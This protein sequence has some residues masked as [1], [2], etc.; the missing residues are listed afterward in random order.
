MG[1]ASFCPKLRVVD[2][3][4]A[5]HGGM[6]CGCLLGMAVASPFLPRSPA[7]IILLLP[8][9]HQLVDHNVA[10]TKE[11]DSTES[12][13]LATSSEKA[14]AF[15]TIM[16]AY[17]RSC[18]AD[19]S[20]KSDAAETVDAIKSPQASIFETIRPVSWEVN[21][22]HSRGM[23][24]LAC[25]PLSLPSEY[26]SDAGDVD[27]AA[28]GPDAAGRVLHGHDGAGAARAARRPAALSARIRHAP[29]ELGRSRRVVGNP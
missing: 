5:D 23:Q 4:W 13:T 9:L 15:R 8:S 19:D 17:V 28:Q 22:H 14:Q 18:L 21:G 3:C 29:C 6:R 10:H 12:S 27:R 7:R 16:L 11:T 26:S 24:T 20:G 1:E 2:G 25:P